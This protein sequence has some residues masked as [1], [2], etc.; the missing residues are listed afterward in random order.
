MIE[1]LLPQCCTCIH[2]SAVAWEPWVCDRRRP[3]C[4]A[5]Q[6]PCSPYLDAT[7][8]AAFQ[9]SLSS[10]ARQVGGLHDAVSPALHNGRYA[11][12]LEGRLQVIQPPL[13]GR[14]PALRRAHIAALHTSKCI[15]SSCLASRPPAAQRLQDQEAPGAERL[16][17]L[18]PP[19]CASS[20]SS[21]PAAHSGS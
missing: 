14:C 12:V 18:L 9:S 10:A 16:G 21:C 20:L 2:G 6:D 11:D 3:A 1:T 8:L 15:L 19:A 17:G 7:A 13:Q 4:D 5:V